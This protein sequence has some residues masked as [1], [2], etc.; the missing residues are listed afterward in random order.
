M[1]VYQEIFEIRTRGSGTLEITHELD[2]VL[3]ASGI[4]AGMLSVFCKH[5]S[6]SLI[7]MENADP[8]ARVDLEAYFD[9]LVPDNDPH[10]THTYE[11]PD[12]MPSHIKMVLTQTNQQV[13]VMEGR[14][15]LGTW[16]GV[17]LWEHR[18]SPHL[19]KLMVTVIGE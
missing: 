1:A 6:A 4:R 5:T 18:T 7:I 14:M 19:R 16:Q 10:F 11:G 15:A 9:R 3:R 13:P 2:R 12:D 8:S 17:F